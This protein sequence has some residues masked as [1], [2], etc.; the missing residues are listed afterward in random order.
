MKA[1]Y[2]LKKLQDATLVMRDTQ[3]AYF[4]EKDPVRKKELLSASKRHEH[5][6]DEVQKTIKTLMDQNQI[7][8]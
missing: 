1:F 5:S 2:L 6:V 8:E 4:S 3:K 7:T